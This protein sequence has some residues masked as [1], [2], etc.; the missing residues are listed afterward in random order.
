M[1]GAGS[2]E[3]WRSNSYNPRLSR[4]RATVEAGNILDRNGTALAVSDGAG[5]RVYP[6]GFAAICHVVGD[7]GYSRTG[8]ETVFG[9]L[10][11]GLDETDGKDFCGCSGATP[12][13]GWT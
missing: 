5:S 9:S 2:R 8:A 4:Q 3:E 12:P 6:Q 10:L 7:R 11:L 1:D 13:K